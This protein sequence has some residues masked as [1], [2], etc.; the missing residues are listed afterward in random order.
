M[1]TLSM[2]LPYVAELLSHLVTLRDKIRGNFI[3][4][5]YRAN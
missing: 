3:L 2:V 1:Y 4:G 5:N